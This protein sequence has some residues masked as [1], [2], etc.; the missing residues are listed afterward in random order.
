MAIYKS[1]KSIC[2]H[3]GANVTFSPFQR[4]TDESFEACLLVVLSFGL[5]LLALSFATESFT[6]SEAFL[7]RRRR[8]LDEEPADPGGDKAFVLFT[9]PPGPL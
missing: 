2:Y 8:R 3:R 4:P 9:Y 6:V 1:K 7:R 5:L